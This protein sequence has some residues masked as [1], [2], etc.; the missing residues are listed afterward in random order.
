MFYLYREVKFQ[1]A[2]KVITEKSTMR[3][4][5]I[6]REICPQSSFLS[7]PYGEKISCRQGAGGFDVIEFSN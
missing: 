4:L 3:L 7:L 1:G 2:L 5:C 6:P